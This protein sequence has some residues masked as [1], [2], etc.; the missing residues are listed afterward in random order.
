[1]KLA[2]FLAVPST[3]R[4]LVDFRVVL[5]TLTELVNSSVFHGYLERDGCFVVVLGTL[6]ELVLFVLCIFRKL[7]DLLVLSSPSG[8]EYLK[9][10]GRFSGCFESSLFLALPDTGRQSRQFPAPQSG[11]MIINNINILKS[12]IH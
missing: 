8:F 4:D 10:V 1:M 9:G 5:S 6:G 2:D 11:L 12:T 7:L 3:L